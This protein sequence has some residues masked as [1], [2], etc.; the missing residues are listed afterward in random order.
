MA[1][2]NLQN[3]TLAF[4]GPVLFDGIGIQIQAGEKICLLGRNGSGK[5]TL[6]KIISGTLEPDSGRVIRDDHVTTAFLSQEVPDDIR[7]SVYDCIASGYLPH[8]DGDD[9]LDTHQEKHKH[10]Q[11]DRIL[12]LLSLDPEPR[13]ETLSA[14]MKRRVLLGRTLV[15]DPHILLLDE[16][17]NHLDM[18]SIEWLE[19]FLSRYEKTVFFVTHDRMFLQKIANRII[20]L[21]RGK[22]YDWKCDYK[23]FLQRKEAWLESE[24]TQNALFDKKLAAEEIWIRK[25]I[26]ARRTRNEGRVRELEKM[27]RDRSLRREQQ[28]SV[29]M[30]IQQTERSGK[31]VIEAE[32]ISFGYGEQDIITSFSTTILRGDRIGII[33]PNGCGKST[34]IRI[35][36]QD[37]AQRTGTVKHGARLETAYF[38]QLRNRL[39]ENK[40]VRENVTDG[41]EII[42][43]NGGK[44]HIIGYLQDF[45]F[46]P[47]RINMPVKAL[48]GGEKNRLLLAKLFT[49]PA[50]LLILDEPTNDLDLETVEL[51]EELLLDFNGTLILVSHDRAFLNNVV[52]STLAFEEN[53]AIRECVGGYDDYKS[54]NTSPEIK[55]PGKNTREKKNSSK[56]KLTFKEKEELESLPRI[57]EEKESRREELFRIMSDPSFYQ[58]SGDMVT[59]I[60]EE[61]R[62]LEDE[63]ESLFV[64]W[65][66]LDRME[67]QF[68][69][70]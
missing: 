38:D 66:E 14:G 50:N 35:L 55:K 9:H 25:G 44:K 49:R 53:G 1:L 57:L 39:D 68:S 23:T 16:P 31:L 20:E 41:N 4:G 65:E 19:T 7:G 64:R 51:L 26:K 8:H 58:K 36:L 11:T 42:D 45:L 59:V 6:M 61:L 3:I 43:F 15:N 27:R 52:T 47:D 69:K 48:S 24:E 63:L 13:F 56:T 5:S 34:L 17:T 29:K 37:L 30:E 2:M 12:S 54:R 28:G 46:T 67:Q 60:K 33:G 18:D 10:T 70:K 22:L 21:D 62:E 32:N 40:T